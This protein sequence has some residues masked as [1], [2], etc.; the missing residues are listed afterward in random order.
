MVVQG[1]MGTVTQALGRAA[2]KAGA[3]IETGRWVA[4]HLAVNLAV[5]LAM[6][7]AMKLA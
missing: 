1:G 3:R 6:Q 4:M 7:L 2:L 5:N